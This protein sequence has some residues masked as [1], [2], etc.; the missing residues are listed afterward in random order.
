V[1]KPNDC[2]VNETEGGGKNDGNFSDSEGSAPKEGISALWA[3][4]I[5][6]YN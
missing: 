2:L 1:E 3:R 6:F 4:T 5:I